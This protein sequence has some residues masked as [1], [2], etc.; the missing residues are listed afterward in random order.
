MSYRDETFALISSV[1][2][3]MKCLEIGVLSANTSRLLLK[4]NIKELYMIDPWLA[5]LKNLP[6]QS[7]CEIMYSSIKKEFITDNR[8]TILRDKWEDVIDI[9]PMFDWILYDI[10]QPEISILTALNKCWG[11]LNPNGI[12]CVSSNHTYD[13]FRAVNRFRE[14]HHNYEVMFFDNGI[15]H[16]CGFRK[17]I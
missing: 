14:M 2:E 11:H 7:D 17:I 8:V 13:T 10:S 16:D 1:K 6:T 9:L 5:P 4:K 3:W 12:L 15:Y